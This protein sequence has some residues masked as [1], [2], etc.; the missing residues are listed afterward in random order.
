MRRTIEDLQGRIERLEAMLRAGGPMQETRGDVDQAALDRAIRDL[1]RG[2]RK[3]LERYLRR[4]GKIWT[5]IP[6]LPGRE[7]VKQ[8]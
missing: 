1:V 7:G 8:K 4:G 2:N 6:T 5:T 3:P